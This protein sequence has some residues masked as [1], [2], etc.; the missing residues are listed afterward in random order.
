MENPQLGEWKI[1]NLVNEK[2]KIICIYQIFSIF[3]V[4]IK[5]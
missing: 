1:L 5:V 4:E 2:Q 3:A